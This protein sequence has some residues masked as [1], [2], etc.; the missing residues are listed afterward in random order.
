MKWGCRKKLACQPGHY[1]LLIRLLAIIA[2]LRPPLRHRSAW[3]GGCSAALSLR[4]P[5]RLFRLLE[6]VGFSGPFSL[7][8]NVNSLF[9]SVRDRDCWVLFAPLLP[10][11]SRVLTVAPG[12][13]APPC[14]RVVLTVGGDG[15]IP[16]HVR[17]FADHLTIEGSPASHW[18]LSLLRM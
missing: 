16:R 7:S 13:R 12:G 15:R 8:R 14:L 5:W 4:L 17:H 3:I 2:N 11:P 1:T 9:H 6:L 18:K 10:P